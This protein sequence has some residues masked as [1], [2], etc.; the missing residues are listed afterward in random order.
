[1]YKKFLVSMLLTMAL[2][3]CGHQSSD[4]QGDQTDTALPVQD[5][6]TNPTTTNGMEQEQAVGPSTVEP[7][8]PAPATTDTTQ[9]AAGTNTTTPPT[10]TTNPDNSTTTLT[11]PVTDKNS[12]TDTGTK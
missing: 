9:P 2:A 3:G 10:T 7:T 11:P 8:Q 4:K 1:M 5:Q 12:S 6:I